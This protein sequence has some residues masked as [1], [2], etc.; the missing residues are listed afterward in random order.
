MLTMQAMMIRKFLLLA[1]LL[2]LASCGSSGGNGWDRPGYN[3]TA[4]NAGRAETGPSRLT[5]EALAKMPQGQVYA[6]YTP[7]GEVVAPA[8]PAPGQQEFDAMIGGIA[9]AGPVAGEM[10]AAVPALP[11][12]KVALL[13]PLSGEHADLGQSMLQAAQL[14]LFDMGYKSFELMP[15]DTRG[16]ASEAANAAQ[17]AISAGAQLVLGPVFAAEVKAVKPV[18]ERNNVNM[19]AFSTDWSLAGGNTFIMG[20]TPFGQVERVAEY[21]AANGI[22]NIAVLAPD[23][24][25]GNAVVSAFNGAAGRTGVRAT[26]IVRFP[27]ENEEETSALIRSFS[28]YDERSKYMED[29]RRPLEERL[30][31]N[32]KDKAAKEELRKIG[33]EA[34]SRLPFQAI[35]LPVG[36]EKAR[37]IGALLDFYE[38]DASVI[39]RLGTGLWDDDTLAPEPSLK[40]AWFSAPSPDLRR[41][42]EMRYRDLYG[43]GAHRL[44]TLAYDATALAA[45]LAQ[46]GFQESGQPAFEARDLANPNGF[47]GLDGIFR[48]RPNGLAERGLAVL[49][50]RNGDIK[51]ISP[52]PKTFQRMDY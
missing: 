23:N 32:P 41:D 28:N 45:V 2:V 34:G 52:A 50:Y 17:A 44:A 35:L 4:A 5:R 13:L 48:F 36:G 3:S 22:R 7:P 47:A 39:K 25:Y 1:A 15:R 24:T 46:K 51:V 43:T 40:G 27:P 20:F 21:A 37:E 38:L 12:V 11:P 29:R 26:N 49:E 6:P 8:Q 33:M 14:A 30:K 18:A 10:A 16:R 31:A 42:F 9:P 19:I